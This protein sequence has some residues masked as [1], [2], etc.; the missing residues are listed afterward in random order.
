[1]SLTLAKDDDFDL[2]NFLVRGRNM[3][4]NNILIVIDMQVD[5]TTGTLKNNDAVNIIPNIVNEIESG[6]YDAVYFTRDTHDENYLNTSEGKRLP[7][8]HCVKGTEGHEIVSELRK[9]ATNENTIDKPTFGYLGWKDVFVTDGQFTTFEQYSPENITLVGTCTDICI[10]SNALIM[11][12]MFPDTNIRV[13]KNCCAGCN[14]VVN[15][16]ALATME[17]CQVEVI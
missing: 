14:S 7:V 2:H 4:K 12:A 16:A 17:Q 15:N 8:T 9:Y 5:F 11:K 13:L 10:A 1:M 6:K 3:K